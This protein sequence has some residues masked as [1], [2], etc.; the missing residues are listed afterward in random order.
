[1]LRNYIIISLRALWKNR[2]HT[3][4]N[5]LG[6]S[7][8]ITCAVVI[9]L[10]VRY[11]LGFDR[12]V[13]DRDRI[14]RVVME[15][16]G[17]HPGYNAGSTYPLPE[18]LRQ[19]F[20]DLEQVTFVDCNFYDP[21]ITITTTDGTVERF[22]EEHAAFVDPEYFKIFPSHWLQGND[23]ALEQEKTV[24]L[25]KSVAR[26]YFG[27]EPAVGKVINFD[28]RFDVTVTGVVNDPPLQTDFPFRLLFSS[29]LGSEDW[30]WKNW[31]STSSSLNCYVKLNPTATK[32]EFDAK[33]DGWH[34]KYFTGDAEDD[35]KGRIYFLQPIRYGLNR[36]KTTLKIRTC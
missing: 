21:V 10:I 36:E 32:K 30:G 19:D 6:L 33:L 34:M 2:S 20:P 16:T 17:D 8:G 28:N 7:L 26:K 11:E 1:M 13:P 15:Y 18:A 22:K 3:I 9:F 25:T 12:N 27:D 35:G 24:V 29:K 5:V 23:H 31:N 4:I 14:Y